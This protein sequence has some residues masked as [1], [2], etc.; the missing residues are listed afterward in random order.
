MSENRTDRFEVSMA[1]AVNMTA[2]QAH[3]LDE[4]AQDIDR[5]IYEGNMSRLGAR[6]VLLKLVE[7][8]EAGQ[9]RAL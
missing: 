2:T 8:L 6:D 7:L 1:D 9:R 5:E 4:I 3:M